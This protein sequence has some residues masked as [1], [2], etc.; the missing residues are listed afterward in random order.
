L[1]YP[2]GVITF[3]ATGVMVV[4]CYFFDY[5]V[6][7]KY[8]AFVAA[9]TVMDHSTRPWAYGWGRIVETSLGIGFAVVLSL[10]IPVPEPKQAEKPRASSE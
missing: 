8:S 10:V 3:E 1:L 6:A 9:L 4:L 2:T 5:A 7:A